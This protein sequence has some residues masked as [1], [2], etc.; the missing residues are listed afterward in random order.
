MEGHDVVLGVFSCLTLK[1]GDF[2]REFGGN[3]RPPRIVSN[4]VI[5]EP[6]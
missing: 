6:S 2:R 1:L 4:G 5:C 3:L